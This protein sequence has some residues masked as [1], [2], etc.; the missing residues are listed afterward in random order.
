M[1]NASDSFIRLLDELA[2]LRGRTN[3]LFGGIRDDAALTEVESVV[4]VA[5]TGA[6]R[7]TTVPQIGRSLGHARQVVQRA[8]D[9]LALRGLV[10]W[11]ENPD[12]KRARLLVPTAAGNA[13]RAE[14]D[15]QGLAVAT[16]VTRGLDPNLIAGAAD[17]LHTI[18]EA[19]DN[20][21]RTEPAQGERNEH[22]FG[23]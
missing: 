23:G 2:R 6:R 14:Q 12:H 3:A 19:L 18:R 11:Q 9:S 7:A 5:V 4:L 10:A 15:A 13:L 17:A 21:L 16:A 1:Q 8:A 20:N 22:A